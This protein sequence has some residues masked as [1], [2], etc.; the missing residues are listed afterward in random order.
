[1]PVSALR[2]TA[3]LGCELLLLVGDDLQQGVDAVNVGQSGLRVWQRIPKKEIRNKKRV[4][5]FLISDTVSRTLDLTLYSR[6]DGPSRNQGS[7]LIEY[8]SGR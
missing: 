6:G 1:M 2:G 8:A 4:R 3:A 5:C 7:A